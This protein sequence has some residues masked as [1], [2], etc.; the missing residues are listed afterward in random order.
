MNLRSATVQLRSSVPRAAW[1]LL[2]LG[3][4]VTAWAA[5]TAHNAQLARLRSRFD[6][7]IERLQ[8]EVRRRIQLSEYGLRGAR[9]TFAIKPDMN[10]AEFAKMVSARNLVR[11]F[12]GQQAFALVVRVPRAAL[13]EFVE[14]V[15]QETGRDFQVKTTGDAADL[16]LVR[17]LAPLEANAA[18]WGLDLGAD[19]VRRAAVENAIATNSATLSGRIVLARNDTR[20]PGWLMMLPVF[21]SPTAA[22]GPDADR[23]LLGVLAAPIEAAELLGDISAFLDYMVDLRLYDGAPEEGRALFDTLENIDPRVQLPYPQRFRDRLFTTERRLTVGGRLLTLR[24]ASTPALEDMPLGI[25]PAALATAAAGTLLSLL[26]AFSA[27]VLLAARS[28]ALR[29]AQFIT[30]DLAQTTSELN[31]SHERLRASEQMLRLV[32]DNIPARIVYWDHELRCGFANRVVAERVGSTPEQMVGRHI[33]DLLPPVR[34]EV[35]LRHAPEVFTGKRVRFEYREADEQGQVNTSL[36]H[37]VPNFSGGQV[38]GFFTLALDVTELHLARDA[39]VQ[40]SQAKS[41]FVANISHEI[42][43]PMNAVLGMLQLVKDTQLTPAQRDCIHKADGAARALLSLLDDILDFSKIEAGRMTLDPRP[44]A[45]AELVRDLAV[46]LTAG[47]GKRRIDLRFD[48]DKRLPDYLVAD[49]LRLRQILVNLGSNALKFTEAGE[50]LLRIALLERSD[51]GVS[52]EFSV[53]DTGIGIAADQLPRLF[54]DF[55]QAEAS[56]TRRFGGTGLGLAISRNLVAMMGGELCVD[57]RPGHGSRFHFRL[58]LPAAQEGAMDSTTLPGL[59]PAD[60]PLYG[61]RVLLVEDNETN[62]FIARELLQVRGATVDVAED[63]R[64]AVERLSLD[65]GYDAVLMDLQMP[66][67]DGLEATRSIRHE[68]GLVALPIIAMTANAMETDRQACMEAGMNAHIAK[69]IDVD[70]L[71]RTLLEHGRGTVGIAA[72]A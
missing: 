54:Q 30:A 45:V 59:L 29:L 9:A 57:S 16:L 55:G 68:L 27:A 51:D 22:V 69:P 8:D 24:A 32:T 44:F 56:T 13:P 60:S 1:V 62:Q 11:E 67:M 28:R 10:A 53:S 19:P 4:L 48:I 3:L 25:A 17:H 41:R 38:V 5:Y 64:E 37:L 31:A 33:G 63:G 36:V 2:A 43:T 52:V 7:H 71:V 12:P 23:D 40:A 66:R 26:L 46:L 50:V 18:A 49:N 6:N 39:A 58:R 34:V 20:G 70:E 42:R 47:L 14:R 65:A 15:R 72:I 21:N 35:T 61:M